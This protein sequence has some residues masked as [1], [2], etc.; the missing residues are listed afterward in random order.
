MSLKNSFG[1]L[2]MLLYV[3][4]LDFPP[5]KNLL[6]PMLCGGTR[7]WVCCGGLIQS[8]PQD[9]VQI[10]RYNQCDRR[11]FPDFTLHS[12]LPVMILDDLTAY[13]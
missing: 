8:R 10:G 4:F 11:S 13:G 5:L 6:S 7:R 3:A 9:F 2:L 1:F 12:D